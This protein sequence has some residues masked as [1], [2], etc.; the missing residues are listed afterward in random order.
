[1]YTRPPRIYTRLTDLDFYIER[2]DV[3]NSKLLFLLS[4]PGLET[5]SYTIKEPYRTDLIAQDYY[6]SDEYEDYVILQ[7]KLPISELKEGLVIELLTKKQLDTILRNEI[8]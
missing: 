2:H 7:T 8:V 3:Y 4:Q 5:E 1:M 6:G